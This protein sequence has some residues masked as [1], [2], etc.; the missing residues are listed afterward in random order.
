MTDRG[1]GGT[2]SINADGPLQAVLEQPGC[3]PLLC[4]ALTGALSWQM[5]NETPVR[6]ALASHRVAPRW[7]AAL[8]ALGSR[9]SVDGEDGPVEIALED[10]LQQRATGKLSVLH[11]APGGPGR[12]W[13]EAHVSRTPAEE[14]IV[15]ACAV[16][17]VADGI[18]QQARVALTGAWPGAARLAVAPAQL[19]GEPLD[20][21]RIR[22][23]AAA[24]VAEVAPKGDYLGSEEYRRAMA[25][26]LTGRAL[27]QCLPQ[28]GGSGE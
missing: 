19:V 14:P 16:V 2:W 11:V 13:G 6:R 18:V 10:L 23:V 24:V 22:A 20:D 9:G 25:G 28:K 15:A 27:R 1:M 26:V 4:V 12:R 7:V 17:E 5:R 21:A 8:L 3:P